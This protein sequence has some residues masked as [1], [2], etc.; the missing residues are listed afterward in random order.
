M[1]NSVLWFQMH[2]CQYWPATK[3]SD[4]WEFS[5]S[6]IAN[7]NL[8]TLTIKGRKLKS[9]FFHSLLFYFFIT[10][11]Y[12]QNALSLLMTL[13]SWQFISVY[14]FKENKLWEIISF[15][16]VLRCKDCQFSK[17]LMLFECVKA[18]ELPTR[19]CNR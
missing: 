18:G 13:T 7:D 3:L 17:I 1:Q 16:L 9:H 6:W 4:S 10:V 12:F 15:S 5:D 8:L 2:C 11:L 14:T 19:E